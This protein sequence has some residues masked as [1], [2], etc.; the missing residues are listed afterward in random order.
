MNSGL[1]REEEQMEKWNRWAGAESATTQFP[2]PN[3]CA[4][5]G[6]GLSFG[7]FCVGLLKAVVRFNVFTLLGLCWCLIVRLCQRL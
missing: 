4:V 5:A 6:K 3:A 7:K 2:S 1:R